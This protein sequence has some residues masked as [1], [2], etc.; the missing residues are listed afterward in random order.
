MNTLNKITEIEFWKS[1]NPEL[2]ISL[3]PFSNQPADI[4]IEDKDA[5]RCLKQVVEEG[6]LCTRPLIREAE[7]KLI[8]QAIDNIAELGLPPVFVYI[9][10][11]TWQIF[12]RLSKIVE[13]ILDPNYKIT[14]AGMWAWHIDSEKS[15]FSIHRDIYAKDNQADGRPAH[16]TVWIPFTDATLLNSCIYVLPTHLDPNYPDNLRCKEITNYG[17]IRAVP[18]KAGSILA[19][20]ANIAHWG[21]KSSPWA[22][23][24]RISIAMDFSRADADLNADDL[25]TYASGP[26][27]N[28]H[29]ASSE[30]SFEQRLNA[31][32]EALSF[33]RNRII[34]Y[35]PEQAEM[36][37]EFF[38]AYSITPEKNDQ[39]A[40]DPANKQDAQ[41]PVTE[42]PQAPAPQLTL[43]PARKCVVLDCDGQGLGVY[44]SEKIAANEIIET[45]H[46]MHVTQEVIKNCSSAFPVD[47]FSYRLSSG[48]IEQV[49]VL[50]FA[51]LYR[52]NIRSN[53]SW[54]QHESTRAFQFYAT[55][56]IDIGEE[57]RINYFLG[58]AVTKKLIPPSKLEVRDSPG[59]GMGVF[60]TT[61]IHEGEVLEDCVVTPLGDKLSAGDAFYDYRFNYP[62][63]V[64]STKRVL[65]L[66]L[67]GV[68]NHSDDNNAYWI[69]HPKIEHVFRFI[70]SRDIAC[71][72]EVC[73]FYGDVSYWEGQNL[74]DIQLT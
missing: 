66:G 29:T 8:A 7:V 68:F 19:W 67:G 14:I 27:L 4:D 12:K 9:Y 30:L 5:E 73:T 35:Y 46:T 39:A 72:E 56:D 70:A 58:K 43:Q 71:D 10:D 34:Q 15:G 63:G 16:L 62:K 74:K 18:A 40:E 36:L 55:K 22:D 44:A 31:I 17:D 24:P 33:Y 50:G 42:P 13:P 69:N 64:G 60:A 37:F 3:A 1:L 51:G 65:A 38:K 2:S 47:R 48:K 52:H 59:K 57:I 26:D 53:A 54:R 6:Y 45:C 25:A 23:R 41:P 49:V 61:A 21:S 32:G 11:Q 20:N 28:S